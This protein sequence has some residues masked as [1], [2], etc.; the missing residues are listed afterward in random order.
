M[1]IL[2]QEVCPLPPGGGAN[3]TPSSTNDDNGN[4]GNNGNNGSLLNV[5]V[6]CCKGTSINNSL[7]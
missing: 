1:K 3:G 7:R 2:P 4:N 6:C 5:S